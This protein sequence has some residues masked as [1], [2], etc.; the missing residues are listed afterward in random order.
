MGV[1]LED[2]IAVRQAVFFSDLHCGCGVGLCPPPEVEELLLDDAGTYAL[3]PLQRKIWRF[4]EQT[5]GQWVPTVVG[6]EPWVLVLNGDLIDG[7]HHHAITQWTQNLAVQERTALASIRH[8]LALASIG[9]QRTAGGA[10]Y[11]KPA[12]IYLV[13]GTESH[14]GPSGENEESLGEKLGAT[15]TESGIYSRWH[16]V[17]KLGDAVVDVQ[18][19]ISAVNSNA[20]ETTALNKEFVIACEEAGRWQRRA[21]DVL[22]R[23]HRHRLGKIEVPTDH[24]SGIV[25]T[26]P[27]WQGKTPYVYRLIGGRQST[28][29]FGAV[30]VRDG[31][32]HVYTK[33]T[34]KTISPPEPEEPTAVLNGE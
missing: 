28:P 5:W 27:G 33:H 26:T 12:A 6:S 1:T 31:A 13:R 7:R 34:V 9:I 32:E 15:P 29:Q 16:L 23:S 3:S 14:V 19:H 20:Y 4:W 10:G 2:R 18:H 22:V 21:P 30:F 8:G 11:D 25:I 24:G 17:L